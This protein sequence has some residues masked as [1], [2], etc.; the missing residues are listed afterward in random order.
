MFK[1]KLGR[2][3]TSWDD[4]PERDTQNILYK[5]HTS[6]CFCCTQCTQKLTKVYPVTLR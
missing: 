6:R 2:Y 1:H 3:T 5:Y 4:S